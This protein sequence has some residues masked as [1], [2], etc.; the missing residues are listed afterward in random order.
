VLIGRLPE[1]GQPLASIAALWP[2]M[3]A[4][5]VGA[6]LATV[7]FIGGIR[8]LGAPRATILS[9]LEPVVG[10]GLAAILFGTLPTA[11]QVAGGA[12]I[13]AAGIVLQLRP[14]GEIAEHEAIA[15]SPG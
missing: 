7:C 6:G 13:I 2:V 3:V 12:L 9:T 10:V 4:G 14:S 15:E 5:V 11:L 1:V 8:L